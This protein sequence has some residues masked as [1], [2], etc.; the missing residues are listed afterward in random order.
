MGKSGEDSPVVKELQ[1]AVRT[2]GTGS[3]FSL[4]K[5]RRLVALQTN[6]LYM[7]SGAQ[8]DSV[9]F[10]NFLLNVLP[11]E[12]VKTFEFSE[13]IVRKYVV[14]GQLGAC[15]SCKTLPNSLLETRNVLEL[16]DPNTRKIVH[17]TDLVNKYFSPEID[18]VG[19]KCYGPGCCPH[20]T[21]ICPGTDLKCQLRPFSRQSHFIQFPKYLFIQLKRFDKTSN[22]PIIKLNTTVIASE[23]LCL[24]NTWYKLIGIINHQ[25][26]Y[27]NGHY[28]TVLKHFNNWFIFDDYQN[29][30]VIPIES[31]FSSDNYVFLFEKLDLS[32][33]ESGINIPELNLNLGKR[34]ADITTD[35]YSKKTVSPKKKQTFSECKPSS[36]KNSLKGKVELEK[37]YFKPEKDYFE[38]EKGHQTQHFA[39]SMI[40]LGKRNASATTDNISPSKTSKLSNIIDENEVSDSQIMCKGC[41]K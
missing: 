21:T 1:D 15:P 33:T 34:S 13:N 28:T 23:S 22:G 20:G 35:N 37:N 30:K 6:H 32:F 10:I 17:L 29:P 2:E 9:E 3:I 26:N 27:D 14:D 38:P 40:N 24:N 41:K 11:S 8:Q 5:L 25:G 7:C 39:K 12:F 16:P 4:S 19:K 18:D 36:F 31:L